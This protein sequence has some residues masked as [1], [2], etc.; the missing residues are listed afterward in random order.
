MSDEAKYSFILGALSAGLMDAVNLNVNVKSN[1]TAER[2]GNALN[3]VGAGS[4]LVDT[5]LNNPIEADESLGVTKG[6]IK[7]YTVAK[8]MAE[9]IKS[10][11]IKATDMNVGKMTQLYGEAGGDLSFLTDPATVS[12]NKNQLSADDLEAGAKAR[13][14]QLNSDTKNANAI[15]R[16]ATGE[17]VTN[18]EQAAVDADPQAQTVL[19]E[20]QGELDMSNTKNALSMAAT[21]STLRSTSSK[22]YQAIVANN[23][24]KAVTNP[25]S[26]AM[27]QLGMKYSVATQ[28][29]AVINKVLDGQS[30]T[31]KEAGAVIVKSP[32][33]RKV[34]ADRLGIELSE[35]STTAD[36]MAAFNS[37]AAEMATIAAQQK[38]LKQTAKVT[39]EAQQQTAAEKAAAIFRRN[40]NEGTAESAPVRAEAGAADAAV[41]A[42]RPR[43]GGDIQGLSGFYPGRDE[44]GTG[45]R[46]LNFSG[47]PRFLSESQIIPAESLTDEQRETKRALAEKGFGNIVFFNGND[48]GYAGRTFFNPDTQTYDVE[49][50]ADG[51]YSVKQY[52]EHEGVHLWLKAIRGEF[53]PQKRKA[54][55]LNYATR[56]VFG[57]DVDAVFNDYLNQYRRMYASVDEAKI[58]ALIR[59][60][61]LAD[62]YAGMAK[63]G[64]D[65]TEYT[66]KVHDLFTEYEIEA[67]AKG[68]LN[69]RLAKAGLINPLFYERM[70]YSLEAD[71]SVFAIDESVEKRTSKLIEVLENDKAK[72]A[73]WNQNGDGKV[74][75]VRKFLERYGVSREEM[76]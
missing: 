39:A 71:D 17:Q 50:R 14:V 31:G 34:V 13:L 69:S 32:I 27:M 42:G 11:T 8:Y 44:T 28:Q 47:R 46:R 4:K 9:G 56:T 10:G 26:Q 52:A 61:M 20:L 30:I 2:L 75:N 51:Q 21:A 35:S 66:E 24:D 76:R 37:K 12:Y 62:A 55:F 38:A 59:E 5:I 7:H 40:D 54:S 53:N 48:T 16:I 33:V 22:A 60:E 18:E 63:F 3:T 6:Q 72:N 36:V 57:S 68:D 49:V 23:S 70:G 29:S 1:V 43:A 41:D 15:V 19:T 64:R 73:P 65:Y 74:M 45:N 58:P 25:T 67:L